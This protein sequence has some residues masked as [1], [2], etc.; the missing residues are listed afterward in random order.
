MGR[1]TALR[2][3]GRELR[4]IPACVLSGDVSVIVG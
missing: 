1:E 3:I 4:A 2:Q